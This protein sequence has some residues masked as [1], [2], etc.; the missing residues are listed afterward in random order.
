MTFPDSVEVE[1]RLEL[2]ECLQVA[3]QRPGHLPDDPEA[4]MAG[5]ARLNGEPLDLPKHVHRLEPVR[6][7]LLEERQ[8][9]LAHLC[10][11]VNALGRERIKNALSAVVDNANT[12]LAAIEAGADVRRGD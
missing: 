3:I 2:G 11:G 12:K 5:F 10:V 9:A 6:E 8:S 4:G 7:R 1:P